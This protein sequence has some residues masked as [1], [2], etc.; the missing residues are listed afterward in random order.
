[1]KNDYSTTVNR[2]PVFERWL[3][4]EKKTPTPPPKLKRDECPSGKAPFRSKSEAG[5]RVV[6][7][8]GQAGARPAISVYYCPLCSRWHTTS[9]RPR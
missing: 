5:E 3:G 2:F 6:L 4:P 7:L 1:M 9:K 8:R